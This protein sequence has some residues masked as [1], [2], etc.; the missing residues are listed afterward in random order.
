MNRRALASIL[1]ILMLLSLLPSAA[2]AEDGSDS[3]APTQGPTGTIYGCVLVYCLDESNSFG[4]PKRLGDYGL[5]AGNYTTDWQPGMTECTATPSE[6]VLSGIIDTVKAL[7]PGHELS[8][9]GRDTVTMEWNAASQTWRDKE[10]DDIRI[11]LKESGA[12]PSS[13]PDSFSRNVRIE[14]WDGDKLAGN[15]YAEYIIESTSLDDVTVSWTQGERRAAV[16]L[17]Q[18]AAAKYVQAYNDKYEES[19]GTHTLREVEPESI[20]YIYTGSGWQVAEAG[21]VFHVYL[22]HPD[23]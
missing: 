21:S 14:C 2:L 1:A 16:T 8:H 7:Y 5:V 3:A 20:E 19:F 9:Y 22:A 11:Y 18:A 15:S 12:A 6:G 10:S 17:N 13:G 4:E 23:E